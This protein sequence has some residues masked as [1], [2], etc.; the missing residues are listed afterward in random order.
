MRG[1]RCLFIIEG[2]PAVIVG[3]ITLWYL[4]DWP[5]QADWLPADEKLWITTELQREKDAKKLRHSYSVWQALRH[6]DVILL[7][8]CYFCAM[9]G[10]FNRLDRVIL[11]FA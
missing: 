2:I 10:P 1:W 7:T 6:R 11:P 4:T 9:T 8:A 5:R 3:V